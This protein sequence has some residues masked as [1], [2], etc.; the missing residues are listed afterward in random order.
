MAFVEMGPVT[1]SL[2]R[3]V[4]KKKKSETVEPLFRRDVPRPVGA[5][6]APIE[7]APLNM[8]EAQERDTLRGLRN[9]I[10]ADKRA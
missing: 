7:T 9:A 4:T 2:M 10:H 5:D 3:L 8:T 6:C 1:N